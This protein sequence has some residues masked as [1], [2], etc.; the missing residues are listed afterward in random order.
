MRV[1][2]SRNLDR[3]KITIFGVDVF[4]EFRKRLKKFDLIYYPNA[5]KRYGASQYYEKYV[6]RH[7]DFTALMVCIIKAVEDFS[8][9]RSGEFFYCLKT[10]CSELIANEAIA[11]METPAHSSTN[12]G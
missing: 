6:C 9:S 4:I 3:F 5:G 2:Y 10:R 12:N 1:Y 7:D 11:A 8:E